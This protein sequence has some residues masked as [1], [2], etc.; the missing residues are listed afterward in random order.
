VTVV[1]GSGNTSITDS[2]RALAVNA[3]ALG[4]GALL[5]LAG[6]SADLVTGLTGNL[7]ATSDSGALGVTTGATTAL[8]IATGTGL[9]LIDASAMTS[10][11]TLTLT[12]AHNAELTVGGNLAAGRDAGALIVIATGTG[13]QTIE[14]GSG[15]DWIT[16]THG[17]DTIEGGGGGDSINVVGHK[18]ADDFVYSATSHS[19]NTAVGHDA[20]AGFVANSTFRDV[21]DF[22]SLNSSLTIAGLLK[23]SSVAADSIGWLYSGGKALIYAKDTS[24]ALTTSS[25]SLMEITLSGVSSGLSASNFKA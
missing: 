3:A 10:G 9:S 17:G 13:P 12:G 1:T 25:S 6:S 15:A 22:S 4:A 2:D 5:T 11:D 24:G 16:A 23:S 18:V 21:V 20:I 19:L 14:T 8:S 7:S